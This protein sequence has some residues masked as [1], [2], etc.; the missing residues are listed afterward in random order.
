MLRWKPGAA[1]DLER[2]SSYLREHA[3]HAESAV[4]TEL[5][6]G[7][8]ALSST[9]Y[10]GRPGSRPG[11]RQLIFVRTRFIVTYR[12]SDTAIQIMRIRHSSRK[13][14]NF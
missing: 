12:V 9:P 4:L 10:V 3:P 8:R 5:F 6:D 13:P 2:V 7:I 11:E 14:L 1:E